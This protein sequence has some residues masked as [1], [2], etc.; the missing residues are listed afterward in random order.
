METAS[1]TL[2]VPV[3]V[4]DRL[5]RLKAHNRQAYHEVITAALDALEQAPV[6]EPGQLDPV[7]ARHR[8]QILKAV[9]ANKG[10]RAWL[11]GSRARGDA[12]PDS[13]VD[14]LVEMAP[15]SSLWNL[16]GM[17]TD[18]ESALPVPFN[19]VSLGGLRGDFRTRVLKDRV[20][21]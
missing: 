4:R 19:L 20:P 11:F 9:K 15:G 5:R 17:W 18:L 3:A 21:L 8:D 6:V 12:R 16:G 13:D 1:T 7:V 2:E 10:V 14:L